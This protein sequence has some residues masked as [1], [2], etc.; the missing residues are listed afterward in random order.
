MRAFVWGLALAVGPAFTPILA[1]PPESADVFVERTGGYFAYRIPAIETAADGSLLAFAE[2]RK[3][4]LDDPG[5]GNQD[6]DLVCRRS[7]DGGKSWSPM[8]LIEDPGERWSAANPATV[9]D[10]TNGRVWL[11]YL[12]CKPGRNTDTARPGTDDSQVLARTS[13]DHG[14]T[15]SDPIDLTRVSRDFNDPKWRCSVV[16]PGGMIQ[17]RRGRLLAACW[18]FGPFGNFALFSEDHGTTWRRSA[19]VPGDAGDECQ[20]VELVSGRLLMDIRQETGAS[21]SFSTSDDGGK[22]WSPHRA[23]L[24]VSPVACA[25]ERYTSKA[26]GD[27]RDRIVW[28]GPKGPGRQNLVVRISEDEGRTFAVE[29]SIASGPAAYSDLTILKDRSIGVLWERGAAHGYQFITF[30][31][32]TREALDPENVHGERR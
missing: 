18:K 8:M 26:A 4:N 15:W 13:D 9:V 20:L 32:L 6:I 24:P 23:G 12:R 16:G 10:R 14:T 28:T 11:L 5:F 25:I 1:A 30:T 17:D 29:R 31:R 27:D 22:T 7:R 3:Y 2:A 21:R 19:P